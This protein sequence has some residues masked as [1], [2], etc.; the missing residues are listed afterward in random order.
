MSSSLINRTAHT[1]GIASSPS[2][3]TIYETPRYSRRDPSLHSPASSYQVRSLGRP[4]GGSLE[5]VK[6]NAFI[7]ESPAVHHVH[8]AEVERSISGS[9]SI[10]PSVPLPQSDMLPPVPDEADSVHLESYN[11][12]V[13]ADLILTSRKPTVSF[14]QA[15]SHT[16]SVTIRI[17]DRSNQ[18]FYLKAGSH[19]GDVSI[20]LPIDFEGPV[21]WSNGTIGTTVFSPEVEARLLHY[22]LEANR[23]KAFLT[24][25]DHEERNDAAWRG[26][27]IVLGSYS[28]QI[29]IAYAHE[30]TW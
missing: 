21:T 13:S 5:L 7:S 29:R 10:D 8:Q 18:R 15:S 26:D 3:Q 28:G 22:S 27:A 17:L 1:N 9:W 6:S 30:G 16:G 19:T 23:G 20:Y 12:S 4:S 24:R 2:Y 11:G 14:I 25:R